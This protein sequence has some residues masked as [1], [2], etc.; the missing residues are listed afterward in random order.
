ME[1]MDNLAKMEMMV[2]MVV[3]AAPGPMA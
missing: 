3:K 2:I 1:L